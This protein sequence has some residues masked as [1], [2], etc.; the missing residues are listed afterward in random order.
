MSRLTS[1]LDLVL[2]DSPP[3]PQLGSQE[4]NSEGQIPT[5]DAN[6]KEANMSNTNAG[7]NISDSEEVCWLLEFAESCMDYHGL[8]GA[9]RDE[10]CRFAR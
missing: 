1:F 5:L 7:N 6:G 10:V 4:Q 2:Q 8:E 9:A 3:S